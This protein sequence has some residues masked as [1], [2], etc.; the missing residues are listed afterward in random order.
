MDDRLVIAGCRAVGP[1]EGGNSSDDV[2]SYTVV[3]R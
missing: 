3:P 1:S 2:A